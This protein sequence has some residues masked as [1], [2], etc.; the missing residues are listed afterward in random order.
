MAHIDPPGWRELAVT[1]AAQREIETLE[2]L[3]RALPDDYTAMGHLLNITATQ[4][5]LLVT[6]HA[7]QV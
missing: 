6:E 5:R 7:D 2:L 3:A 4:A 1:G